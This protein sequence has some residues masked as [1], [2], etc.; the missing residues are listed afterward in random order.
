MTHGGSKYLI[1]DESGRPG[2]TFNLKL[3]DCFCCIFRKSAPRGSRPWGTSPVHSAQFRCSLL[4]K[5]PAFNPL[6]ID[7]RCAGLCVAMD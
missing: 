5:C 3:G 7:L 2:R 6:G 4:G 1:L